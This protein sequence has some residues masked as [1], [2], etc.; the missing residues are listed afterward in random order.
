MA[1]GLAAHYA[2]WRLMQWALFLMGLAAYIL[3]LFWFPE[4]LDPEVAKEKFRAAGGVEGRRFVWLNPVKSL[5]ML[6]SPNILIV[7]SG[8]VVRLYWLL[9]M[10]S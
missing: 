10:C 2:S 7:V 4:T 8:V 9:L 3:V 1:G 6:R 5:A